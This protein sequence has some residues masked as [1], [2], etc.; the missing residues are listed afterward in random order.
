MQIRFA[1]ESSLLCEP[2]GDTLIEKDGR[3]AQRFRRLH[4][5]VPEPVHNAAPDTE[6]VRQLPPEKEEL[7]TPDGP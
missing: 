2:S 4:R 6:P 5:P 1:D 7:E 3:E